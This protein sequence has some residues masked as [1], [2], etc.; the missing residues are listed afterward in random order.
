MGSVLEK[1]RDKAQKAADRHDFPLAAFRCDELRAAAAAALGPD[2]PRTLAALSRA[3]MSLLLAAWESKEEVRGL[4]D[5]QECLEAAVSCAE[6]ALAGGRLPEEEA[7][8]AREIQISS[9]GLAGKRGLQS[10]RLSAPVP[11]A[12]ALEAL[13]PAG[14]GGPYAAGGDPPGLPGDPAL[15][16]E[17]G[18]DVLAA[19]LAAAS[20]KEGPASRA[21]VAA[22]SRLGL[23]AYS[24]SRH[25]REVA[26]AGSRKD[27]ARAS[28]EPAALMEETYSELSGSGRLLDSLSQD[29]AARLALMLTDDCGPVR[30]LPRDP[31][32]M[33]SK[34]DIFRAIDLWSAIA[35]CPVKGRRAR[36]READAVMRFAECAA[37]LGDGELFSKA[38][39]FVMEETDPTGP[40]RLAP[41]S[42]RPARVVFLSAEVFASDGK[43]Q[44][45]SSLFDSALFFFRL[46]LGHACRE[47]ARTMARL[48]DIC[49]SSGRRHRAAAVRL[50]AAEA[51]EAAVRREAAEGLGPRDDRDIY[52]LRA[53]AA[54]VFVKAGDM[55]DAEAVLTPAAEALERLDGR[56]SRG[57]R[58]AAGLLARARGTRGEGGPPE[59]G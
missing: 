42:V 26:W 46:R 20:G 57:F 49:D 40:H 59:A 7:K 9:R 55:G 22:R 58:M 15:P 32:D 35:I 6:G 3:G 27:A 50:Q 53:M 56:A 31:A 29:A 52:V 41:D 45:A 5:Q 24:A 14:D 16:P 43:L 13:W 51:L 54:R 33:P 30:V 39:S 21:A 18:A 17:P 28:G 38:V 36:T 2:D 47:T 8:F 10:Q 12:G 4:P 11:A 37:M 25:S 1:L 34:A 19:E 48:A 44:E 23:A